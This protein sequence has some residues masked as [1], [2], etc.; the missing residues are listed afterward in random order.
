MQVEAEAEH[1]LLAMVQHLMVVLL[2]L[3]EQV[4]AVLQVRLVHG[5]LV[6]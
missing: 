5:L 2:E 6:L 1:M 3:E 4:V